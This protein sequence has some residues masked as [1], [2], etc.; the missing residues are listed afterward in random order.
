[1]KEEPV[2]PKV[3]EPKPEKKH[4]GQAK[5]EKEGLIDKLMQAKEKK[6][7]DEGAAD[8]KKAEVFSGDKF[9]DLPI[10]DKLKVALG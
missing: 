2:E 6:V 9:A 3:K 4:R 8:A 5:A 10:N 7:V 1:M